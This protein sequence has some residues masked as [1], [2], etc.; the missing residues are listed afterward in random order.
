MKKYLIN[1]TQIGLL[2]FALILQNEYTDQ[3][4]N[5]YS[6]IVYVITGLLTLCCL[7]SPEKI[8]EEFKTSKIRFFH[9][10]QIVKIIL[11]SLNGFN[12]AAMCLLF[13]IG[14]IYC[15]LKTKEA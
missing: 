4:V 12:V 8:I 9:T 1:F 13:T 14:F 2:V 3:L 15:L 7:L 10:M 11:L 6:Y 5:L